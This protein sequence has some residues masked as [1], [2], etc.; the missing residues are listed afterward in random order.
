M[1]RGRTPRLAQVAASG[2]PRWCPQRGTRTTGRLGPSPAACNPPHRDHTMN[3]ELSNLNDG[4]KGLTIEG[5]ARC[6][7]TGRSTG[8][9]VHAGVLDWPNG[10]EPQGRDV[11]RGLP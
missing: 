6:S 3:P 8:P 11:A 7:G 2:R 5:A 10:R 1:G 4:S 9:Q